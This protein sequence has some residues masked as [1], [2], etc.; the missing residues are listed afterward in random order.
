MSSPEAPKVAVQVLNFNGLHWLRTCI[1]SLLKTTYPNLDV[2]VVDNGSTDGS[3]TFLKTNHPEVRLIQLE[4]NFGFA[5]AYNKAVAQTDAKYV[6]LLNNDTTILNP[7]WVNSLVAVAERNKRIAAVQCKIVSMGNPRII[8]SLGGMGIRY[9]R[10]F[11]DIGKHDEDNGQY[12]QPSFSPFSI[13]AAA[14]LIQ[15]QAFEYV[16]GF[17][18][19]LFVFNEDVDLS[20]RL[21]LLGYD[22]AYEP[23]AVIAHSSSG[24]LGEKEAG[25]RKTY[26]GNRNLIRAVV[27]N[28]GDSLGW[29]LR[30]SILFTVLLI[31][32]FS[33]AEP[34]KAVS[35]IRGLFW[36]LRQFE[37]TYRLRTHIQSMR[38]VS[39]SEILSKMYPPHPRYEPSDYTAFRRVLNII[40]DR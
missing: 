22:V 34:R 23:T 19:E 32:G 37:K 14:A 11:I 6:L 26:Y 13:C 4:R 33:L 28:C 2:F 1:P 15:K 20:W 31:L 8:D 9:W 36:N 7:E 10:G 38:K 29:A 21:R 27:K 3:A 18:S 5:G 25:V 16:G 12:D 24:T 30:T 17:D 39:E 35:L 40:F